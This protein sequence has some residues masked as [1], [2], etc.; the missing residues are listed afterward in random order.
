MGWLKCSGIRISYLVRE[1]ANR[2]T[3][4]LTL[5][6]LP[7]SACISLAILNLGTSAAKYQINNDGTGVTNKPYTPTDASRLCKSNGNV[8]IFTMSLLKLNFRRKGKQ[9]GLVRN[10]SRQAMPKALNQSWSVDFM[11][12]GPAGHLTFGTVQ[13]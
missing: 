12:D 13:N 3:Y 8:V 1:V 7:K 4:S 5:N 2:R 9:R 6:G 10:S 11:H